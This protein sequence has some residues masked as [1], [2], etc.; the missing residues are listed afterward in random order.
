MRAVPVI[1]SITRRT[2]GRVRKRRST[3]T[4]L[5]RTRNHSRTTASAT[6]GRIRVSAAVASG[7]RNCGISAT[8]KTAAFGLCNLLNPKAAVFFVA[9]MPQFLRP[10]AT[11][12]D[13]L[14]LPIV[15]LAVVLLWFLVLANV[16]TVLR[17]FLTRPRVRRVIDAITG[18][19][20]IGLGVRLAATRA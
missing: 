20:L 4:T 2:R 7:R 16:V 6:I 8:K 13:T 5:A 9:L 3:V 17:R 19:A 11:A 12:A 10:D 15:A 18:T 14:I 1:A